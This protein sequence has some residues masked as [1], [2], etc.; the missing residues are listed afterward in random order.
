[1]FMVF[2]G[3]QVTLWKCCSL[4]IRRFDLL[5][6]VF[7]RPLSSAIPFFL[8]S[9]ETFS[10]SLEHGSRAN[11][12]S[13]WETQRVSEVLRGVSPERAAAPE[14]TARVGAAGPARSGGSS[15]ICPRPRCPLCVILRCV[16]VLAGLV[17][18]ADL[19]LWQTLHWMVFLR[20]LLSFLSLCWGFIA[21]FSGEKNNKK[22]FLQISLVTSSEMLRTGAYFCSG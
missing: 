13:T 8:R 16:T 10:L 20:E 9:L 4:G 21:Q 15:C 1:M 22:G 7:P 14:L 17:P 3:I 12:S 19:C 5:F 2:P 6:P 11:S 18:P